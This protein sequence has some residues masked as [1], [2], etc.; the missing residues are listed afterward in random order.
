MFHGCANRDRVRRHPHRAARTGERRRECPG[1][2]GDQTIDLDSPTLARTLCP[3]L[4]QPAGAVYPDGRFTLAETFRPLPGCAGHRRAVRFAPPAALRPA[5]ALGGQL[6]GDRVGPRP[7]LGRGFAGARLADG[8][9]FGVPV[10]RPIRRLRELVLLPHRSAGCTWSPATPAAR[11]ARRRRGS[12]ARAG[13]VSSGCG[14]RR[15]SAAGAAAAGPAAGRGA[16]PASRASP[17]GGP[18]ARTCPP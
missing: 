12:A 8:R 16:S 14:R 5:G 1:P 15:R 6:E 10:P 3:P 7:A 18:R 9:R 13:S 11:G 4:R 2:G 17:A